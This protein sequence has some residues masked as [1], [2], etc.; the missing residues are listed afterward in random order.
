MILV[1]RNNRIAAKRLVVTV[2][3]ASKIALGLQF[4]L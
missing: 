4:K 2:V 3:A 1:R